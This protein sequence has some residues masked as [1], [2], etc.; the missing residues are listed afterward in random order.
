MKKLNLFAVACFAIVISSCNQN[1]PAPASSSPSSSPTTTPTSSMTATEAALVGDWIFDK[2]E[3]Y[4]GGNLNATCTQSTSINSSGIVTTYTLYSGAHMDFKSSFL[5]NTVYTPIEPQYYNADYYPGNSPAYSGSW[6]VRPKA[7]GETLFLINLQGPFIHTGNNMP[8]I[9]T[10]N[11]TTLI[12]Q[13]WIP[14]QIPNGY[15][16][17]FH[18]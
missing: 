12:Y 3:Q 5:N 6:Q 18:K 15:K 14:G 11:A 4:L 17:Y 9:I 13:Q 16:Y 2:Y 10:L 1:S 8:Y 7:S